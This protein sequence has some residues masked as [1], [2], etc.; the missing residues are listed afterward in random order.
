MDGYEYLLETARQEFD[1]AQQYQD[2]RNPAEHDNALRRAV[3]Y[4]AVAQA[5]A[6]CRIADVLAAHSPAPGEEGL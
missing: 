2:D 1:A 4:A 6:L 3:A 5:A